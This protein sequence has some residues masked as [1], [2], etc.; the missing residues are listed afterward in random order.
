VGLDPMSDSRPVRVC[1][2]VCV[3]VCVCMCVRAQERG[4]R[5]DSVCGSVY[6]CGCLCEYIYVCVR[7]RIFVRLCKC[8]VGQNATRAHKHT[9]THTNTHTHTSAVL[10]QVTSPNGEYCSDGPSLTVYRLKSSRTTPPHLSNLPQTSFALSSVQRP[11]GL[12]VVEPG[13]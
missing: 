3:C 6:G 11:P 12:Q 8:I 4:K 13:A 7:A 1:A 2:S 10:A 9:H 5:R